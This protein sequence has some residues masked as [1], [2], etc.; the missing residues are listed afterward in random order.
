MLYKYI[1][2]YNALSPLQVEENK[3][4]SRSAEQLEQR[5]VEAEREG[6]RLRE[7]AVDSQGLLDTIS[8]DKE[9]LSQAMAQNRE[10]K[11]QLVELQDAFVRM[12]EQSMQLAT[13]LETER[14]TVTQ[15]L[16]QRQATEEEE[17]ERLTQREE[18]REGERGDVAMTEEGREGV[19]VTELQAQRQVTDKERED[20]KSGG[21]EEAGTD[22][23]TKTG[24]GEGEGRRREGVEE[25]MQ[26]RGESM[27]VQP[28]YTHLAA[29][30]QV[31]GFFT[32]GI[33]HIGL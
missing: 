8:H 33:I 28:E 13:D 31:D 10:L 23:S 3:R 15:L 4:L 16:A 22:V 14:F 27:D 1:H 6:V 24:G 32:A 7:A 20:E 26:T 21:A 25:G 19:T 18:E 11:A 5:A 17:R 29:M 12:S 9:A 2:V 30:L